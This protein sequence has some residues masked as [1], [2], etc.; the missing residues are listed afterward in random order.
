MKRKIMAVLLTCAVLAAAGCQGKNE[1]PGQETQAGT[2][3]SEQA[4]SNAA[5]SFS[6]AYNAED[7]VT[8]GDYKNLA[9]TLNEA[10]YEVTEESIN[11]YVDGQIASSKPYVADESKTVIAEGDIVDVDYV[12]KKDGTAFDGGSAENQYIDVSGNSNAVMGN[13]YIEGFTDGLIGAKVGD[14]VDCNVTFPEQYQSQEL[15]GQ[16]VVFTFTVNAICRKIERDDLDDAYVL[17]NFQAKSVE[18]F[19]ENARAAVETEMK[20]QKEADIRAKAAE[21]LEKLCTVNSYPEG[22]LEARLDEY[23]TRFREYYCSDGT[24]LNDFLQENAGMTE[25]EFIE[26]TKASLEKSLKEELIFEAVAAKEGMTADEKEYQ[27]YISDVMAN[28]SFSSEDAL[29][30]SLG[31]DKESGKQYF[32]RVYLAEQAWDLV[33]EN[34]VVTYE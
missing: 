8:L 3:V 6:I 34:A 20:D 15:A 7:F 14:T 4:Q 26:E 33:V 23:L 28:G 32:Q 25:E 31:V 19:Y 30:E 18:A 1:Q 29:Y 13:G 27:A 9:L 17:E 11:N 12:G 2:E 21:E 5:S 24:D 10:D 16:P 22:L